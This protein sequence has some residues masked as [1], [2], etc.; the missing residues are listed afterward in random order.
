MVTSKDLFVKLNLYLC[1]FKSNPM[2]ARGLLREKT[3]TYQYDNHLGSACLE[4]DVAGLIISYEEYHPFGTTSYRSG[5]NEVDVSLKRYKY[6]GKE[7]D[8]ETG[9]YYY[10]MRYYAAWLCRFIN[11]DPLQF[12]YP[13]YT[14]F[15]YAGNKPITYI[16]LDG[17]EEKK[18]EKQ[19]TTT[20]TTDAG[21]GMAKKGNIIASGSVDGKYYEKDYALKIE[22]QIDFWLEEF[23]VPNLRIREGDL[24]VEEN[25]INYRWKIANENHSIIFISIHLDC[26]SCPDDLVAIYESDQANSSESKKLAE[27]IISNSKTLTPAKNS[28][29]TS[30]EYTEVKS[31]AVLREFKGK[32]AVLLELGSIGG[33]ST[34]D[35]I[36]EKGS[37]IGKEIATAIYIYLY[38][39]TPQTKAD[40]EKFKITNEN[41]FETITPPVHTKVVKTIYF[42]PYEKAPH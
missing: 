16:D 32:A 17:G 29:K 30:K 10:G 35:L 13:Y 5:A 27:L 36:D 20:T 12:K 33:K 4:L 21:H 31:V 11:V 41:Y 39:K 23:G 3:Q 1:P 18:I 6:C 2:N 34:R 42:F 15:Q 40:R 22:K 26:A 9:L 25:T 28:I 14:P 24:T 38:N 7:R 8:E 19:K 37:E